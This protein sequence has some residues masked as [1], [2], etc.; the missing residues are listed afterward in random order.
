MCG[1]KTER[2][3][4]RKGQN[5]RIEY[6]KISKEGRGTGGCKKGARK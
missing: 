2:K 3:D 1:S 4:G 5:E 6:G